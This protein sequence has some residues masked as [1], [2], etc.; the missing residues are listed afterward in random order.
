VRV[1]LR[2]LG[3]AGVLCLMLGALVP[4]A[5]AAE[6]TRT[7][8]KAQVEPICKTNIEAN[9]RIFKGAKGEVEAGKLKQA[10]KHFA[11]AKTAFEKTIKQ[12]QAVP[13][14]SE[15]ETKLGKW[16]GYLKVDS[17]YIGKIGEALN[18]EKKNKA[19]SLSVR[20]NHNSKLA[21]NTVLAFGF[22]YCRIDSSRFS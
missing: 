19:Q 2:E 7:E 15:D 6:V 11:R 3:T 17:S 4:L 18:A 13:E 9:K 5:S 16:I 1:R 22:N 14:P 12:I 10:A 20:L 8:Y 21:N